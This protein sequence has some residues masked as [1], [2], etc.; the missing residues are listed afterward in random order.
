MSKFQNQG[1][2]DQVKTRRWDAVDYLNSPQDISAYLEAA[3]EDG[4]PQLIIAAI[5]DVARAKGMTAIAAQTGVGRESLYKALSSE[6]NPAFATV[7]RV[8]Q[9]LG[10]RLQ[11]SEI[12]IGNVQS[13]TAPEFWAT[14]FAPLSSDLF[15][16]S[17]ESPSVP[18]ARKPAHR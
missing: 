8:L 10:V 15:V 1:A 16:Y 2:T 5:G 14:G 9:T 6:G 17:G 12:G 18:V 3:F 13:D 11:T 7:F 4:D